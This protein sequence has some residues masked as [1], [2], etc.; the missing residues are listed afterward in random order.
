[1][2]RR[3]IL[4]VNPIHRDQGRAPSEFEAVSDLLRY[5]PD[6]AAPVLELTSFNTK[7]ANPRLI[8]LAIAAL[9]P[10]RANGEPI[11]LAAEFERHG[12]DAVTEF[13]RDHRSN[14]AARGFSP[15]REALPRSRT[16]RCCA[17]TSSTRLR[18][19]A[20]ARVTLWASCAA[21]APRSSSWPHGSSRPGWRR[22]HL[23][24]RR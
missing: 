21:V 8:L 13:V 19:R 6:R 16:R 10:A 12:T 22:V 5:T 7:N 3:A 15:K 14:A 23:S 24:G 2:L 17:A 1:M 9:A 20:C 11:D 18:R 4:S